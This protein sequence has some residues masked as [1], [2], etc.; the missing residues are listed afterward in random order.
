[1]P[2]RRA[3]TAWDA[4]ASNTA[5]TAGIS[6][7]PC[8]RSGR[9]QASAPVSPHV[10]RRATPDGY[11][12]DCWPA[13]DRLARVAQKQVDGAYWGPL[14]DHGVGFCFDCWQHYL[15]TGDRQAI[16]EAYPRL[17]RFAAYLES[18][19]AHDGLLPVEDL[20]IPPCGSITT[21]IGRPAQA[22]RGQPL[23]RGDVQARL[24]PAGH[25]VWRA[26]PRGRL[27]RLGDELLPPRFAVIGAE[28]KTFIDNLPWLGEEKTPRTAIGRWRPP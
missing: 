16:E 9:T 4:N 23:R 6:F 26:N 11:F 13:Y 20:G 14:L 15:D 21:P 28:R 27:R 24:G 7:W 17:V 3:S 18:S 22:V 12:L 1:M 5:E 25:S 19:A 8:E 10:Q 2:K